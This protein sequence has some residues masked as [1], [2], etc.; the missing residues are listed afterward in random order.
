[1]VSS[2]DDA[3]W[4]PSDVAVGPD[5]ALYI[6]DWYDSVVGG[7]NMN[8]WE[9]GRIYRLAPPGFEPDTAPRSSARE[10]RKRR[11]PRSL[12]CHIPPGILFEIVC[13]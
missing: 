1:M 13:R 4:R 7:H 5:G 9:K 6:A 10:T 3:Q 12:H 2:S 8:D 11:E